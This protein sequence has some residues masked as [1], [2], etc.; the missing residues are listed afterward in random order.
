M[1]MQTIN[2]HGDSGYRKEIPS[3]KNTSCQRL[4]VLIYSMFV[5]VVLIEPAY[6][7][8]M[9][10]LFH[11]IFSICKY[12]AAGSSIFL[13][14]I[15]KPRLNRLLLGCLFYEMILLFSTILHSASL[16][17]WIKNCA[18]MV[19]FLFFLQVIMEIDGEVLLY[20]LSIVLG[21]YTNL[22]TLSWLAYPKGMYRHPLGYQNCWFLGYDNVA[23]SIIVVAVTVCLFRI[24]L[25]RGTRMFWDWIV[26]LSGIWFIF[27]LRV[28]TAIFALAGFFLLLIGTRKKKLRKFIGNAQLVVLGMLGLFFLI[29]FFDV[30]QSDTFLYVCR[31]LKKNISLSSRTILW[32]KAWRDLT[33]G[34]ILLGLGVH[35]SAEYAKHFGQGW[36]VHLHCYYLQVLYEGGILAFGTLF[37]WIFYV[38]KIFDRTDHR[39]CAMTVLGGVLTLMF[40]WQ[41]EASNNLIRYFIIV[42]FLLYNVRHFE[43]MKFRGMTKRYRMVFRPIE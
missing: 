10:G 36:I 21:T 25:Y 19:A 4:A 3:R 24:F 34:N 33:G 43:N 9:Q 1:T 31:L 30:Q 13:Y 23:A 18:Y 27:A 29:Q 28:A 26:V 15:R 20:A 32:K 41:A 37:S 38:A 5:I 16:N 17:T 2:N 6:V 8:Q 42:L 40:M 12:L 14:L 39:Y 22:N 11:R 35:E 7:S